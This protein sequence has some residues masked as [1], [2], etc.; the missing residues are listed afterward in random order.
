MV[1]MAADI[2]SPGYRANR[3]TQAQTNAAEHEVACIRVLEFVLVTP[4]SALLLLAHGNGSTVD[5][6]RFW[7]IPKIVVNGHSGL[8]SV[9][10]RI[11]V[12]F[13]RCRKFAEN[14]H[15]Y[16]PSRTG[17]RLEAAA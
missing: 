4:K 8:F 16:C 17:Y 15:G 12:P 2:R 13:L 3:R 14:E 10:L 5:D 1:Q 9:I 11:D 7:L 6:A